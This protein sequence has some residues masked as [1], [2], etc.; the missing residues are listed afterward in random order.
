MIVPIGVTMTTAA[1]EQ[2][3]HSLLAKLEFRSSYIQFGNVAVAK[4]NSSKNNQVTSL[5]DGAIDHYACVTMTKMLAY[6]TYDS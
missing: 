5:K 6:V 2:P 3:S 4:F 1:V